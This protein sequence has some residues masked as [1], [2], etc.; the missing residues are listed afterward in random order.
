MTNEIS[1][2]VVKVDRELHKKIK[3]TCAVDG[4]SIREY[5]ISLV[6]KDMKERDEHNQNK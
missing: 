6:E 1:S 5:I 3:A 4:I 2:L